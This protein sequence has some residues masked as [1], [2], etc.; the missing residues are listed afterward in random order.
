MT[1]QKIISIFLLASYFT[2]AAQDPQKRLTDSLI[3]AIPATVDDSGK[4][5]LYNRIFNECAAFDLDKALYYARQGLAHVQHMRWT[6]GIAV[7]QDNLGR[8]FSRLGNYDSSIH[9]YSAALLSNKAV[10][11]K[12]GMANTYNNLGVAAQN[13]KADYTTAADYYFKALAISETIKDSVS[14]ANTLQNIA[15]IYMLQKNYERA[16]SFNKRSM[17]I[18]EKLGN[19]DDVGASLQSI[20]KTFLLMKDTT[21]AKEN[22]QKGLSIFESNANK[23]GM[24]GAWANM[25][26]VYGNNFRAVVEARIKS[27]QLWDEINPMH[28]EAI[29]N[30]G[31]LGIIYLDIAKAGKGAILKYDSIVPNN[32]ILL[33]D[34]AVSYLRAAVQFAQQTGDIDN[35][36]FFT[37][38]LAEVQEEQGDFKNAYL[39]YK[40][41]K[42]TEDSIYSQESKNSIAAAESRQALELKE[43]A[44]SSQ[45]KTLWGLLAVLGL[46]MLIGLL[47]YRQAVLRKQSNKK[48]TLL[49]TA[50][51]EANQSKARFFAVMSHDLRSPVSRLINFLHLQKNEPSLL[52]PELIEIHN[53]KITESAE[54]LLENMETMLMWSKSQMEQFIPSR[55]KINTDDVLLKLQRSFASYESVQFS[56]VHG[57][58][59]TCVSDEN[60]LFS[61]LYNLIQNSAEALGKAPNAAIECK[62][63]L[64]QEKVCFVITDNGPG[65]PDPLLG[66]KYDPGTA[67]SGRKGLGLFIIYDMAAAIHA[68]VSLSNNSSG[69]RAEVMLNIV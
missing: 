48:L 28:P 21:K 44:L 59:L 67:I 10:D 52:T 9:Y 16:L 37:G 8:V 43:L 53:N 14:Q 54:A 61:I 29:T 50:L 6:K 22:F 47:L 57:N 69:A 56:F 65:F 25:S 13:T 46:L 36:S 18:R 4:A 63:L 51:D 26:M 68:T 1:M 58:A 2:V 38:A 12:Q 19:L 5:R 40:L 15:A 64:K 27:R 30:L 45:R 41:F 60:Y 33:L 66:N 62:A 24:A 49:N 34:K 39:N 23:E 20:G 42:E 55:K 7:F 17:R 31:N 11:N 35:H 3:H 32:K